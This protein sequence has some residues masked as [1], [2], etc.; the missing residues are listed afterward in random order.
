MGKE[1]KT[2]A[3]IDAS[4]LFYGGEK[5]LG[6]SVDYRKLLGY[7]KKKYGVSKAFYYAGLDIG[8]YQSKGKEVDLDNLIK[9]F[10]TRLKYP[11]LSEAEIVLIGRYIQRAK[12][13]K[14]LSL[15]GYDL[16]IK[17]VKV[18]GF[19]ESQTKKANCDVDL[20]FD[21]MRYMSQYTNLVIL[22]GDGDFAPVLNYLRRK[23]KKLSILARSGRTASE[24]KQLAGGNFAD[25]TYLRK[26][27]EFERP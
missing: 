7:L 26:E 2:Y 5:S 21:L 17:P 3:F 14:K 6:W 9:H 19:G 24:I 12:F 18:F 25:F 13:Y 16:R 4:N 11:K 10:R 22:S 15:F 20:T 23:G 1:G 8:R 27:L